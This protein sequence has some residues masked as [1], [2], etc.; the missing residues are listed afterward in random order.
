MDI[1]KVKRIIAREGLIIIG[2]YGTA[3]LLVFI[4][5]NTFFNF[6]GLFLGYI[7]YPF[8]LLIRFIIWAVNTLKKE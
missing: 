8:Y 1:K 7:G 6:I 3:L 2:V 4:G 5:S